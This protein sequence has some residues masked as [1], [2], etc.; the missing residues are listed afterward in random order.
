MPVLD[1]QSRTGV[2][3]K[4]AVGSSWNLDAIETLCGIRF[5]IEVEVLTDL[6]E[7]SVDGF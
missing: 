4:S 2:E 3:V 1:I 5:G 6:V 7:L